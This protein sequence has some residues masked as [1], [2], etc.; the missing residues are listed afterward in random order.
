M[1]SPTRDVEHKQA[2]MPLHEASVVQEQRV[3]IFFNYFRVGYA[4]PWEAHQP[5]SFALSREFSVMRSPTFSLYVSGCN[6]IFALCPSDDGRRLSVSP[7][8]MQ[9]VRAA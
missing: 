4:E 7:W 5:V 1:A 6:S 2:L 8:S 9:I 3:S